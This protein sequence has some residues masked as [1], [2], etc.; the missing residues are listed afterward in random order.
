MSEKPTNIVKGRGAQFNP[1]N[2]FSHL[3]K[4][5]SFSHTSDTKFLIT[6]AKTIVNK[7]TSPDVHMP[8]SM[9]PYQ[10]CEH[11]CVYCYARNTHPYWGYSAGLD[12]EQTVLIKHEAPSLLR[13]FLDRRQYECQPIMLSGN[14]DCY[15]PAEKTYQLTRKLLEVCLEYRQPVGIITKNALLLRDID[16]LKSLA[17]D[18]LIQVVISITT[19][20]ETLR[21]KLEPRTSTITKRLGIVTAL[22]E[23]HIPVSVI[24]APLIP[25]LTDHEI[26]D[27]VKISQQAGA[28]DF[29]YTILR[30]NG[31]VEKIFKDWAFKM[32]PDRAQKVLNQTAECHGGTVSDQRFTTRMKGEGKIAEIIKGQVLLAKKRFNLPNKFKTSLNCSKFCRPGSQLGLFD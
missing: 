14:T 29:Y 26:F 3:I 15:Q 17:Q 16:I 4:D 22:N 6:H 27:L 20:D 12:F 2:P 21:L 28:W 1:T 11:G 9:N 31:D 7:V 13:K 25:G 10:G 23:Q 30:L 32:I 19:L 18:N 8:Y 24:M 5:E